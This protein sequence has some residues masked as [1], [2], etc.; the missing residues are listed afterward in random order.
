MR[1]RLL[2]ACALALSSLTGLA[3]AQD[4]STPDTDGGGIVGGSY[5]RLGAGGFLPI[6]AS[7]SYRDWNAAK[8]FSAMWENWGTSGDGVDNVGFGIGATYAAMPFNEQQFLASFQTLQGASATSASAPSASIF[9][10]ET[11]LRY[12][13]STPVVMPSLILGLGYIDFQ[14]STIRYDA[15]AGN[16]TTSQRRKNGGEVSLGIGLDRQLMD[17]YALFAEA[18]YMYGFTSLGAGLATP[19]A[20]CTNNGCDVLKNIAAGT[21]RAGLRVRV[22]R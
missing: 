20:T 10:I 19:A 12:R 18:M 15:V 2:V 9:T 13:F 5:V 14:P 8:G 6:D 4:P 21:V 11:N 3:N 17:R 7:G 22:G 1:S 16:G